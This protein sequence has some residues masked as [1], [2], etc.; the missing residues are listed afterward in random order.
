MK[1][2]T[3]LVSVDNSYSNKPY[4][5]LNLF[6]DSIK[7]IISHYSGDSK[8]YVNMKNDLTA[9]SDSN[10]PSLEVIGA[11]QFL[12]QRIKMINYLDEFVNSSLEARELQDILLNP[13]CFLDS[14]K[15]YEDVFFSKKEIEM[16]KLQIGKSE[17]K[18]NTIK[19]K[20]IMEKFQL[21]QNTIPANAEI[22]PKTSHKI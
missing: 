16:L 18:I 2:I 1:K 6:L 21:E 3:L 8:V 20:S 11:P 12:V 5:T 10:S 7:E 19:L 13:D 9:K 15:E 4:R 14:I 22:K 17:N